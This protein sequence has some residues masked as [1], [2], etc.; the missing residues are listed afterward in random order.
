M[1]EE[2]IKI[3]LSIPL[4]RLD[5]ENVNANFRVGDEELETMKTRLKTKKLGGLLESKDAFW[6]TPPPTTTN[7][8]NCNASGGKSG[9]ARKEEMQRR[10][11]AL[12]LID[13]RDYAVDE[14][15]DE[16]SA[17]EREKFNVTANAK[18]KNTKKDQKGKGRCSNGRN[19]GG[20][21]GGGA[22][23]SSD[24]SGGSGGGKSSDDSGRS[25]VTDG[26]RSGAKSGGGS[27]VGGG[28]SNIVFGS[29]VQSLEVL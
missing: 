4:E 20:G 1:S 17:A 26:K 12:S 24:E 22:G 7:G 23:K 13:N 19:G 8:W 21:G 28:G 3:L 9:R 29:C 15:L 2:L 5:P 16:K 18:E 14:V 27:G 11:E 6:R 25:D 10:V